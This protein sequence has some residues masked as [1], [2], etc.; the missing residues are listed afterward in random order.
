MAGLVRGF[1]GPRVIVRTIAGKKPIL[2]SFLQLLACAGNIIGRRY[3]QIQSDVT[4][5]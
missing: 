2:H 4:S 3:Y 5:Q 1:P